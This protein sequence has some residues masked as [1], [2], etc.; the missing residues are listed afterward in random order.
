V[1]KQFHGLITVLGL[2][3]FSNHALSE[4]KTCDMYSAYENPNTL[5]QSKEIT[6]YI[7]NDQHLGPVKD[8]D[9]TGFC[10]A[11][12]GADMVEVWLKNKKSLSKNQS[13][14]PMGI[15]LNYHKKDWE[16]KTADFQILAIKRDLLAPKINSIRSKISETRDK[17][18]KNRDEYNQL[19]DTHMKKHPKNGEL[20][21]L[22]DRMTNPDQD[23]LMIK[24]QNKMATY[25]ELQNSISGLRDKIENEIK[26]SPA[27]LADTKDID[28][29]IIDLEKA[30]E[31]FHNLLWKLKAE[32]RGADEDIPKG[33]IT[34]DALEQAWP[35][36]CLEAEV[37]SRDEEIKRVYDSYRE[38]LENSSYTPNNFQ[39]TLGYLYSTRYSPDQIDC[40]YFQFTKALFP[41]LPY[42]NPSDFY[43]FISKLN[44]Y[45]NIF[46]SLLKKS[47]SK[48]DFKPKPI[49]VEEKIPHFLPLNDNSK[50][51]DHIDK[52]LV[53]GNIAT[54]SYRSNILNQENLDKDDDTYHASTIV[55]SMNLCGEPFYV[56]RNTWGKYACKEKNRNYRSSKKRRKL[57][58]Q[59][60]NKK[61]DCIDRTRA[62]VDN[63]FPIC[64]N[65]LCLE[66]A[67]ALDSKLN[68]ECDKIHMD[69]VNRKLEHPFFCDSNGNFIIKKSHLKKAVHRATTITN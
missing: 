33:G 37:N 6:N 29:E 28:E 31:H 49:I 47:C 8:Q 3:I 13:V 11:F 21:K 42:E 67:N 1:I 62:E 12:A 2:S 57:R 41:R 36:M 24:S 52:G 14:S 63:Q 26:Q 7:K 35:S 34:K 61:W 51:F 32:I 43:K 58:K 64:E 46:D 65:D 48:K 16:S 9:S 45:D 25:R 50:I 59:I 66:Q 55:G 38:M 20:N 23:E 54:I 69:E 60:L 5:D 27:F 18:Y 4:A 22:R 44:V 15:G 40:S 19:L 53:S 17:R 39:D 30:D 56:L 68:A 10:Y